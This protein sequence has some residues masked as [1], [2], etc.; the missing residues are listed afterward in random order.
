MELHMGL[1]HSGHV[2][3][4]ATIT[5]G[6]KQDVLVGRQSA[7]PKGSLLAI[8]KGYTGYG[9]YKQLTDKG[10]FFVTHQ[11]TNAKFRVV[12]RRPVRR[13]HGLTSEQIIE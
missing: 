13:A 11:R 9:W 5:E 3:A 7:F 6:S 8:G 1:A 4:F 10:I 12:A 2:P